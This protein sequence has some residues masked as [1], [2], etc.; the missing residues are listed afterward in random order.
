VARVL[1]TGYTT[2]DTGASL[3]NLDSFVSGRYA[4]QAAGSTLTNWIVRPAVAKALSKLKVETGSNQSL[5]QFVDDG[6]VVA[7]L[8]VLRWRRTPCSGIPQART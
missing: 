2:V 7:G 1:I 8:P 6:I 4:A 3:T 5:L